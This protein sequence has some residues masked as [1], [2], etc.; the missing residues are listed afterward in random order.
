MIGILRGRTGRKRGRTGRK[1]GLCVSVL[2]LVAGTALVATSATPAFASGETEVCTVYNA[3]GGNYPPFYCIN[4]WNGGPDEKSYQWSSAPN[5]YWYAQGVDRCNNGDYTTANC[6]ISGIGAGRFIYQLVYGNNGKCMG[7]QT[8]AGAGFAQGVF[9]G[10]NETGYPGVGGG[11]GTIQIAIGGHGCPS[12]T[13]AA[14]NGYW[15]GQNGGV[16]DPTY[17]SVPDG[18]GGEVFMDSQG[19]GLCLGQYT[20]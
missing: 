16:S 5:N 12:A 11:I 8:A 15:T 1:L 7:T 9:T 10:C 4:A 19:S 14:L 2:T 17:I 6:P 20:F 3:G 18:N 13:N